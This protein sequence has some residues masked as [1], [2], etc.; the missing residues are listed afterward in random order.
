MLKIPKNLDIIIN[1]PKTYNS[2]IY[3]LNY[4]IF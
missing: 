2:W 1:K 3:L 4:P